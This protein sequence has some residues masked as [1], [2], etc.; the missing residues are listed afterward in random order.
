[1]EA[2][3]IEATGIK[4]LKIGY[5]RVFGYYIEVSKNQAENVPLHYKR[6]QTIANNERFITPDLKEI[7]DVVLNSEE[8]ALKLENEIYDQL[9][10]YLQKYMTV[11]QQI[12]Q[13]IAQVD[14][15][16]SLAEVAVKNNYV[17][18]KINSNIKHIKIEEGRHPDDQAG[19]RRAPGRH[20][21]LPGG[22]SFF[23]GVPE[24]E[25]GR[26]YPQGDLR[27]VSRKVC[28]SGDGLSFW[29]RTGRRRQ[30]AGSLCGD[31]RL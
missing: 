24:D 7:E 25:R 2:K 18:P 31:L 30:Y 13:S 16:L 22:M 27:G 29:I 15:L 19:T 14:A 26:F 11:F 6:R 4:N 21:G 5:N 12:S 23:G 17:K 9:K 8:K 20:Y 3:E 28:C 1:M 10:N